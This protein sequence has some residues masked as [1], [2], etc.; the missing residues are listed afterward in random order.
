MAPYNVPKSIDFVDQLPRTEA[1]KIN[2][3][4]LFAAR[5]EHTR[6]LPTR[7]GPS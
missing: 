1:T 7:K 6:A 2:R 5:T 3:A 4:Q